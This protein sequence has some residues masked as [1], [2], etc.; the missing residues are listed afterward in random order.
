MADGERAEMVLMELFNESGGENNFAEGVSEL[1]QLQKNMKKRP[2]ESQ[3]VRRWSNLRDKSIT[4]VKAWEQDFTYPRGLSPGCQDFFPLGNERDRERSYRVGPSFCRGFADE[5]KIFPQFR[6]T[7]RLTRR[8]R[9]HCGFERR[10]DE[11][12]P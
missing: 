4:L 9:W 3:R 6:R 2:A 11:I 12:R 7:C 8:R 10:T 1:E 5:T